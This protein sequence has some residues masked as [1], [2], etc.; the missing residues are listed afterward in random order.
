MKKSQAAGV[1]REVG[2]GVAEVELAQSR[3][4]DPGVEGVVVEEEGVE[5]VGE[6]AVT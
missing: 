3:S 1:Q 2:V 6:E 5:E 4:Q